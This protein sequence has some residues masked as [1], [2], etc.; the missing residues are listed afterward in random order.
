MKVFRSFAGQHLVAAMVVDFHTDAH[1]DLVI[2]G[3]IF[4]GF[5]SQAGVRQVCTLSGSLFGL[6]FHGFIVVL[7]ALDSLEAQRAGLRHRVFP[8]RMTLQLSWTI[9][10]FGSGWRLL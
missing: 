7:S 5:P 9:S 4:P 2:N 6:A 10:G 3:D 8:L 1:A